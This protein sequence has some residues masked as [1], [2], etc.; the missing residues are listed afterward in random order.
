MSLPSAAPAAPSIPAPP[1]GDAG[2]TV[3]PAP[4]AATPAVP[5]AATP[6][7]PAA[8][9]AAPAVTPPAFAVKLPEG[10]EDNAVT[11]QAMEKFGLTSKQGQGL[12]DHFHKQYVEAQKAN[13]AQQKAL[14]EKMVNEYRSDPAIGGPKLAETEA[15]AQ[16]ADAAGLVPQR[17]NA[18]AKELG[19]ENH[20]AVKELKAAL[21]K[22]LANDTIAASLRGSQPGGQNDSSF[23]PEFRQR[24]AAM[25]GT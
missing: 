9:A 25:K 11:V 22:L 8:P 20:V 2:N 14:A 15:L 13:E 17:F 16:R 10:F 6:A 1:P 3:V 7:T 21:G 18:L 24:I 5:A 4:A 23:S 12:I 19:L